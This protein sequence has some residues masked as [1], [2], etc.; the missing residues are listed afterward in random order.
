MHKLFLI[1]F[2]VLIFTGAEAQYY[3]NYLIENVPAF[4]VKTAV[5]KN[6]RD[7]D[8]EVLKKNKVQEIRIKNSEG[9]YTHKLLINNFGYMEEYAEFNPAED[10]LTAQ[11]RLGYDVNNNLTAVTRREGRIRMGHILTYENNLLASIQVDSSGDQR[12]FDFA[13]SPDKKIM[14]VTLLDL[15]KDTTAEKY[16]FEYDAE[17]RLLGVSDESKTNFICDITFDNNTINISVRGNYT[18]N[19]KT[20]NNRIT[21]ESRSAFDSNP[22]EYST[23]KY[24]Y[25]ENGLITEVQRVKDNIFST[26]KYEYVFYTQ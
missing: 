3:D 16:F 12:Q 1:L 15:A 22:G 14:T 23:A 9:Q 21:E 25:G 6:I 10:R 5:N 24:F 17:G 26:E 20:E 13:Y 18:L 8:A 2:S 19:Y 11:W 4:I 7:A